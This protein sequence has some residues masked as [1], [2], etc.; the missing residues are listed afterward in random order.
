MLAHGCNDMSLFDYP[1]RAAWQAVLAAFGLAYGM[2]ALLGIAIA[3][4]PLLFLG[5]VVAALLAVALV[6]TRWRKEPDLAACAMGTAFLLAMAASAGVLTYPLAAVSGSLRDGEFMA[7]ER[8]LG[9]DWPEVA[10][11]LAARGRLQLAWEIVYESSLLQMVI[12]V[13]VLSFAGLRQRLADY[14]QLLFLSLVVT[15]ALSCLLPAV[16]PISSYHLASAATAGLGDAGL[17]HLADFFAL[18]EGGFALFDLYKMEGIITFPSYHCVL[19]VLTA[20]ALWPVRFAGRAALALNALVIVSTIPQGGHYL[21]D[22]CVGTAIAVLGLVLS[23]MPRGHA[24][25]L[26]LARAG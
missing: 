22:M 16:G 15:A 18:R 10:N 2:L 19:A 14:L 7:F 26:V 11:A 17:R 23:Q 9:F 25:A 4:P 13:I 5:S 24:R 12:T 21:A 1:S 3:L 6:Y 20:W 8:A